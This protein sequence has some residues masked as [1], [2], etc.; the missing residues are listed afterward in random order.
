[1]S[2]MTLAEIMK[3]LYYKKDAYFLDMFGKIKHNQ[4][5]LYSDRNNCVSEKH[6]ERWLCMNDL[7]NINVYLNDGWIPDW[8]NTKESKYIIRIEGEKLMVTQ[9]DSPS[10]FT[11]FK[12]KDLAEK[13]INII[14]EKAL[15]KIL[16]G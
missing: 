14:G 9:T 5:T 15:K 6:I 13:A 12:S 16:L 2:S 11:Y 1:M 3:S 7:L 10:A 4:T 8:N